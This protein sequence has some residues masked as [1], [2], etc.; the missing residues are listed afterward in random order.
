MHD[1]HFDPHHA[2]VNIVQEVIRHYVQSDGSL[3]NI[4]QAIQQVSLFSQCRSC[5]DT[6]EEEAAFDDLAKIYVFMY[7]PA[8]CFV[9]RDTNQFSLD[10]LHV[11][12]FASKP[13]AKGKEITNMICGMA[14]VLEQET[15]DLISYWKASS[16]ECQAGGNT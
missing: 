2:P 12:V 9:L 11:A 7:V 6:T 4:H 5:L 15:Q 10:H 3:S 13:I 8:T 14:L 1:L 16:L